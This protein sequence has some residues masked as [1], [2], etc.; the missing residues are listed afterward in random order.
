MPTKPDKKQTP[1]KAGIPKTT[2]IKKTVAKPKK[3]VEEDDLGLEEDEAVPK[4]DK[5]SI[6][7]KSKAG[8]E[9]ESDH[10]VN[11]FEEDEE[12]HVKKGETD[13]NWDPDF[14]EF[15]LPK[16][17]KKSAFKKNT[18]ENDDDYKIDDEFKDLFSSR[19]SSSRKYNE[20]DDY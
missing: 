1:K 15:D 18:K 13:G 6:S 5:K 12:T 20:D 2:G 7:G 16:S 17:S 14:E 9:F 11:D 4:I 10:D 19:S 8:D 3:A